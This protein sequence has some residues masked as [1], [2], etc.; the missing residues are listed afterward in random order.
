MRVTVRYLAAVLPLV[1]VGGCGCTL[2]QAPFDYCNPAIGPTGCLNC[3]F[4]A[5]RGSIFHPMDD[6]PHVGKAVAAQSQPQTAAADEPGQF[7]DQAPDD[8]QLAAAGRS[9]PRQP[10][11]SRA[12]AGP[13][14][15]R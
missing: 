3:D 14:W 6:D 1:F 7:V 13:R 11:R 4:D 8:A 9:T 2:C 15:R 10:P 5:R 12:A